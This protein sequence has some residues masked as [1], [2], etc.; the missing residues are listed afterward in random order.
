[1][2]GI[3][4]WV[5]WEL[6]LTGELKTIQNMNLRLSH[7]GPDADGIWRSA[8]V[9]LA[10]RR[11]VVVD[12]EGG[13][14]PMTR[15][16]QGSIYTIVYN[17]E[18][19]NT[20]ELR[21]ELQA[22]GCIFETANS[23]TET[24]LLAYMEWGPA[25]VEKFNGIFAFAIWDEDRESLFMA[26]D[27]L[28]VKPLFYNPRDTGLLFASE[29]KALLAHPWVEPD[30]DEEGLAE[31][32]LM[33]PSRTPGHAVFRGIKE[34]RPGHS[35]IFN[36][37]GINIQRYWALES[38]P[39]EDDL[40]KT[41]DTVRQLFI[42]TVTRQ[43]VADVP[44]CTLLSGGLDSSAIT[45]VA[46]GEFRKSG[47][48][49]LHSFSVDYQGNQEYF[50]PSH[51]QPDSDAAWVELVS[52]HLG[53]EHHQIKLGNKELA[54][55]LEAAMIANDLP[56]MAD[57][58]SSLY[59]FCREIKKQATVALSGECADEIFGGY[60]WFYDRQMLGS[61]TFPWIRMIDA[62]MDFLSPE[63]VARIR[64]REYLADRYREAVGETPLLPGENTQAA[65]T[66][67][68]FYLNITRF[69]PTLLDRKDRMSMACGLEVRV[70]F[71][72]HRLLQ[73]VWNI[74]WE[75]KT[76]DNMPKGILRR[77]MRGVLPE[78]VLN[79]PKSPYPKTHHPQYLALMRERLNN[80]LNDSSSLLLDIINANALKEILAG[81]SNVM[82]RPFFGQLMGEAQYLAFL[83][84]LDTWLRMYKVKIR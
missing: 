7:R 17:G 4:G 26:R 43:L 83:I 59:L 84:Q 37:G 10:H 79:R 67:Q 71:S 23:D 73:Y 38:H 30:I 8:S 76:C 42:D 74:P 69:M 22:R 9:A 16:R 15:S 50:R 49:R 14:Q 51:F 2:C 5:D 82:P 13:A 52:A 81:S 56:G 60:P 66:R 28:G 57:I 24:L 55:A 47:R 80:I 34:L 20:P 35:L 32:L 72:D 29:L 25:C 44:V 19:Y 21:R 6:D 27:R 48:D 75:M 33:G 36:R 58:D 78:A 77:A 61:D 40:I 54:D 1:M 12:P 11:L 70:P 3:S 53:T 39:H 46:A 63:I 65:R 62:R 18:L 64:P 41:A 31:L 45:A 68:M